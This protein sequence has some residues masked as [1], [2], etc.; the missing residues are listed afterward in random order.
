MNPCLSYS[1]TFLGSPVAEDAVA[2]LSFLRR[3]FPP[4]GGDS[5]GVSW[6]GQSGG[7]VK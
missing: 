6:R 2:G 4:V 1:A 3:K 5:R 7:G